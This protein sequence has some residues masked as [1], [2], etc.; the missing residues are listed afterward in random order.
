MSSENPLNAGACPGGLSAP[1]ESMR[2]VRV[3]DFEPAASVSADQRAA[4]VRRF[5]TL[6]VSDA[7]EQR[8]GMAR[9]AC[10][11][12]AQ[13]ER[14]AVKL[15]ALPERED[16]EPADAYDRRVA[17]LRAAFQHEY[18]C[19]SRLSGLKG[20]PRLYGRGNVEGTPAIIMEWIEGVTL[21]RAARALAV[22]DAGRLS[23]L[24]AARIARD[25]FDLIAR[26]DV[27]D[28]GLAHRDISPR[29][30]MV[31]TSRLALADQVDEGA[32]DLYLIDFGS[33]AQIS[34]RPTSFTA[35]NAVVRGA[36]ADFAP[37]EMLSDDLPE[38]D[39][40][41]KSSSIDVY[42]AASVAYRLAAGRAPYELQGV[43][44]ADG[45]VAS[46]YRV[47]MAAPPAAPVMAH[48]GRDDIAALLVREPE[49]AVAVRHAQDKLANPC[50]PADL[51]RALVQ[52]DGLFAQVILDCLARE[53]G[54]R[55]DAAAVRDALTSFSLHYAD[56]VS[57]A[58]SGQ[59]LIPCVPGGLAGGVADTLSG[60]LAA[61]RTAAYCV[62]GVAAAGVAISACVLAD[63]VH[64]AFSAF[65]LAWSGKLLGPAVL[66]AL[67]AAPAVGLAARGRGRRTRAGFARGSFALLIALGAL[68]ALVSF[69]QFTPTG[70]ASVL[71]RALFA[72]AA[73]GWFVLVCDFALNVVVPKVALRR[74]LPAPMPAGGA[75]IGGV[76]AAGELGEAEPADSAASE[77]TEPAD[78]AAC[79]PADSAPEPADDEP[80]Q[81]YEADEGDA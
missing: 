3:D 38:L 43:V 58:L 26:M 6:F 20:F 17:G 55:P 44:L 54:D 41:R 80:Q 68:G 35:S 62:A 11:R 39:R 14:L 15:L 37:P 32:F 45:E 5:V 67:L 13:A 64:A 66:V 49:V 24:T 10:A 53:Q 16:D 23:P 52:V 72:C 76:E 59:P 34:G 18:E 40:L 42:A 4:Y 1:A 22:D 70:A 33:S 60:T 61:V 2:V 7:R 65:G 77:A 73:A 69:T 48:A 71:H 63:G 25:V 29:N 56:N 47:K 50:P 28:G 51:R 30:V 46:P 12:N 81:T 75:A 74:G 78:S 8:G 9:I 19:H 31:R 57:R 79:E 27:I 36:T 21:A